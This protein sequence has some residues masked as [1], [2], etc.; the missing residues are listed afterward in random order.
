MLER[1][2]NVMSGAGETITR[3]RVKLL[4]SDLNSNPRVPVMAQ[5]VKNL[6]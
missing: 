6:T 5:R 1:D 3:W 2:W 4:E